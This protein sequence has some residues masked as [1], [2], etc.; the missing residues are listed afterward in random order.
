MIVALYA[1]SRPAN[2]SIDMDANK[3]MALTMVVLIYAQIG[4]VVPRSPLSQ[5]RPSPG[6]GLA[7]GVA[8]GVLMI[9]ASSPIR[10]FG[11][12][13]MDAAGAWSALGFATPLIATG[14]VAASV[15]W[16]TSTLSAGVA[17]AVC[18][19]M[20]ASLVFCIGL[21]MLTYLGTGWF[22]RDPATVSSWVMTQS[23]GYYADFRQQ[24]LDI[25][26]YLVRQN[27]ES[28]FISLLV[29]PILGVGFGMLGATFVRLLHPGRPRNAGR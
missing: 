28:A 29:G 10:P 21:M 18:A 24:D 8:I 27:G 6:I 3:W 19:A 14:V 11:N 7:V 13:N 16:R 17:T 20:V 23:S 12:V 1:N 9:G 25:T 26:K 15:A 4:F 5:A 2:L 22:I